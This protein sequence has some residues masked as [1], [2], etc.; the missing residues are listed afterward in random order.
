MRSRHALTS[1]GPGLHDL[2]GSAS[3]T[4][5]HVIHWNLNTSH[6]L[7]HLLGTVLQM[8]NSLTSMGRIPVC[9]IVTGIIQTTGIYG[10]LITG[11][12][13]RLRDGRKMNVTVVSL[14][15]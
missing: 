4:V 5:D 1:F 6:G 11:K 8:H 14:Y 7:K 12:Q 13:F 9:S 15:K 3:R 10:K 2:Q